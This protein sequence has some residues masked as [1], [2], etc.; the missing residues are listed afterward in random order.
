ME[1]GLSIVI[2]CIAESDRKFF[3]SVLGLIAVSKPGLHI[4]TTVSSQQIAKFSEYSICTDE[5]GL[6]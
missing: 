1:N 5:I 2:F 3:D 6:S 4:P